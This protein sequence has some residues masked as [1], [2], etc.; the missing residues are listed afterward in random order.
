M[1]STGHGPYQFLFPPV[2]MLVFARS[3]ALYDSEPYFLL[4]WA[5]DS[6]APA[7]ALT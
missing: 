1:V 4:R 7:L 2:A 3:N 6:L 5:V